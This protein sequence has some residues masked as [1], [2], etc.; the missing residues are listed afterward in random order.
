ML[1]CRECKHAKQIQEVRS[2]EGQEM[3]LENQY[4]WILC[5]LSGIPETCHLNERYPKSC[6]LLGSNPINTSNL[7][8][9]RVCGTYTINEKGCQNLNHKN[10]LDKLLKDDKI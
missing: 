9:C 8:L 6:E 7:K 5:D 2:F 10:N 1:K 3:A 4:Y